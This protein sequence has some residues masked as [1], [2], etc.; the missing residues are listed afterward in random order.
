[1]CNLSIS[2]KFTKFSLR[3]KAATAAKGVQGL[4]RRRSA[5]GQLHGQLRGS[6]RL[7]P[8][9]LRPPQGALCGCAVWARGRQD[10]DALRMSL[11]LSVPPLTGPGACAA[12]S[13]LGL[14]ISRQRQP[15]PSCDSLSGPPPPRGCAAVTEFLASALLFTLPPHSSHS[16]AWLLPSTPTL[17]LATRLGASPSR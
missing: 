15:L 7:P 16:P 17:S 11:R 13:H 6:S 4:M 10:A 14:G 1:M 3:G 5:A 12:S 2:F 9:A 8:S